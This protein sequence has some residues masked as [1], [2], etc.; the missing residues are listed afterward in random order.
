MLLMCIV[1]VWKIEDFLAK[2]EGTCSKGTGGSTNSSS[3]A[4]DPA[5]AAIALVLLKEIDCYRY[6]SRLTS[7]RTGCAAFALL[8]VVPA[9]GSSIL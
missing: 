3:V 9:V 2:W 4:S 7:V 6:E 8:R 5:K 1:Q